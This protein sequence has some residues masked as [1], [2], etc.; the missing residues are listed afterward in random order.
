MNNAIER[1]LSQLNLLAENKLNEVLN[2]YPVLSSNQ[3]GL[4]HDSLLNQDN[5]AYNLGM[6]WEVDESEI[7]ESDI[8]NTLLALVYENRTF[9]SVFYEHHGQ[10]HLIPF[11]E[12]E[13]KVESNQFDSEDLFLDF[14]KTEYAKPF[15]LKNEFPARFY[16]SRYNKKLH[17]CCFFNHIIMDGFSIALVKQRIASRQGEKNQKIDFFDYLYHLPKKV[18]DESFDKWRDYYKN[19][20]SKELTWGAAS[21][22][23][24]SQAKIFD[25]PL[26]GF[27]DAIDFT[28]SK[29]IQLFTVFHYALA[30]AVEEI[31]GQNSFFLGCTDQNRARPGTQSL[32]GYFARTIKLVSVLDPAQDVID[33]LKRLDEKNLQAFSLPALSIHEVVNNVTGHD[34]ERPYQVVLELQ[35][36][37]SNSSS[38]L[39]ESEL[40]S[41]IFSRNAKN[42]LSVFVFVT[43]NQQAKVSIEYDSSVVT[44]PTLMKL[45]T[46]FNQHL[47][48]VC[49]SEARNQRESGL[50]FLQGSRTTNDFSICNAMQTLCQKQTLAFL[51]RESISFAQMSVRV[52]Q[53]ASYICQHYAV[54]QYV[55][56]YAPRTP[57]TIIAL[58]GCWLAG[59]VGILIPP[60]LP[61]ERG[62][63]FFNTLKLDKLISLDAAPDYCYGHKIEN[64]GQN[65][66]SY[67][68]SAEQLHSAGYI[69]FS[70]GTT[71][72]PKG[73]VIGQNA[74][75]NLG[76]FLSSISMP[77]QRFAL[78]AEFSFD[79]SYQQ[80]LQVCLGK[81]VYILNQ[82]ERL[83]LEQMAATLNQHKIEG[84]DCT[85]SQLQLFF[86]EG[87]F[88]KVPSLQWMLVG[89]EKIN[90]DL[91]HKIKKCPQVQFINVY[92]PCECAVDT[93][94]EVIDKDTPNDAI[95][96]PICHTDVGIYSDTHDLLQ[97]GEIG[98]IALFGPSVGE[99]YVNDQTL[100][101]KQFIELDTPTGKNKGYM[102][103]DLGYI[104][105]DNRVY[106]IGRKDSQ[107]KIHGVRVE[108]EEINI[109]VRHIHGVQDAYSVFHKD[110]GCIS[111]YYISSE[112][113]SDD[114]IK[115]SIADELGRHL[116]AYMLP[117]NY[118]RVREFP[119]NTSGKIDVKA[120]V[121]YASVSGDNI[122]NM[123]QASAAEN[124]LIELLAAKTNITISDPTQSIFNFGA[125]S[126]FL[127]KVLK[128][129]NATY[130]VRVTIGQIMEN[131]TIR[132]INQHIERA[133]EKTTV[134]RTILN[135]LK[136]SENSDAC[137]VLFHPV[138]GELNGYYTLVNQLD[139]GI[140]IYGIESPAEL[141]LKS[142]VSFDDL[143]QLYARELI[144]H[145]GNR[146][147]HLIGWSYGG[148][149]AFE[150][151]RKLVSKKTCHSH[152]VKTVT[153]IDCAYSGH[154]N[155][156]DE[157]NNAITSVL[158]G[159]TKGQ[160]S[161]EK[162]LN[163]WQDNTPILCNE[164]KYQYGVEIT[165][166]SLS[167]MIKT[168]LWH[169]D[170][171][172]THDFDRTS[173]IP[174]D[175]NIVWATKTL[176]HLSVNQVHWEHL[177]ENTVRAFQVNGDHY[178]IMQNVDLPVLVNNVFKE[179]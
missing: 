70:S 89:G 118:Y 153:L 133:I 178:S 3:M 22:E 157:V 27:Q 142:N 146:K 45:V 175:I 95:G 64:I 66:S 116:P 2:A 15:Y 14:L 62:R 84:M 96:Y 166:E 9:R 23:I 17:I 156:A 71:G 138:G 124:A 151:A 73:V 80:I 85:P 38:L 101:L 135:Q 102:T 92:G 160:F 105:P 170:I 90:A 83:N 125:N 93:V 32:I 159:L 144:E 33:Q 134:K 60:G 24:G 162:D 55:G 174:C 130:K 21:W 39:R 98:E 100:T 81:S 163:A 44:Y 141:R 40:G 25:F 10:V 57:E 12:Q 43:D 150:V 132:H 69:I 48:N 36:L 158:N 143:C 56:I 29:N 28:K 91:L 6:I 120:L 8:K 5:N 79:A 114:D 58:L 169:R 16:L 68:F 176:S 52:N 26:M 104:A 177:S 88:E 121:N 35:R 61:D 51:N 76:Q 4:W 173:K 63:H 165:P 54:G 20:A 103:G 72:K 136:P 112:L 49:G 50:A 126:L 129:I 147:I 59:R 37:T 113:N 154:F 164:L 77:I 140:P 131:P 139:A 11:S 117:T 111:V 149:V 168:V 74:I 86:E 46:A 123:S 82:E 108:L 145:C 179:I 19:F 122:V 128:A 75:A 94:F 7:S 67:E 99:G 119:L 127:F 110:A 148:V 109:R 106:I 107:I 13:F 78:N 171:L 152:G 41:R 172:R 30:K 42:D 31:T 1:V 87:L 115:T 65:R 97:T 167:E 18:D 137:I 161:S 47:L 155:M 34:I 53:C